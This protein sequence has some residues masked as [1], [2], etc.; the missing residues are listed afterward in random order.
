LGV[1]SLFFNLVFVTGKK[2]L[3]MKYAKDLREL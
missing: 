3:C 2:S 1:S